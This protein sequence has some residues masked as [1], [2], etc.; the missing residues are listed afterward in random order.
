MYR[1]KLIDGTLVAIRSLRM[2]KGHNSQIYTHHIELISKLRHSH[3]VSALGH[4][5]AYDT[6]ASSVSNIYLIFEFVPYGTLRSS[7]GDKVIS[8]LAS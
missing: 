2:K 7:K 8:H 4:C 1:G 3:L 5:L 6:D